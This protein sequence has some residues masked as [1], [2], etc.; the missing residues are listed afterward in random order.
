MYYL[1]YHAQRWMI[2]S[3]EYLHNFVFDL[4]NSQAI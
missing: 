1:N 3:T 4:H 2:L